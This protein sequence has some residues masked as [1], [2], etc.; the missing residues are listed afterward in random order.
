MNFT[1]DTEKLMKFFMSRIDKFSGV[2]TPLKQKK[3]DNILKMMYYDIK[4][5]D[6]WTNAEETQ[7][8]IRTHL[9]EGKENIAPSWVMEESKY[10]PTYIQNYI[11]EHNKGYIQY[12]L[13]IGDRDIEIYFSLLNNSDFNSL[14]QFDKYV[15]KMMT[16]LKIAFSYAPHKCSR[17]LKIYVFLTPFK[18][19]LPNNQ[20]HV[21]SQD[22]CNSA[23]TMSCN[24]HGEI[25]VYRK[26]EFFKVFIHETFHTLGLDFSTM[27][28][29]KFNEK[30]K[31]IFPIKSDF[32]LF[33]SYSEF[34]ASTMTIL[35]S[36]YFLLDDKADEENFYLYCD[37]CMRFEK[38]FALF[39]LVK[40]LDFMGLKYPN[41]Y[42]CD[43]ISL[44]ARRY[45]FKEKTNVFAYYIIKTL[46]L[47]NNVD[48]LLWCKKNNNNFI[49]FNKS[50][51]MLNIFLDFIKNIHNDTYFLNDIS[52]MGG[53]LSKMKGS[54][55]KPKHN[56]LTKTMRM[57]LCEIN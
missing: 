1:E 56:L 42:S 11:I 31:N 3:M 48:F 9:T 53:F 21:L 32:N 19:K 2:K 27:P 41:L 50:P 12:K 10:I 26:E 46:L 23:V 47:Y 25:I 24:P 14:G 38:M 7:N 18:K 43:K 15:K 52:R 6:M 17:V 54:H 4:S 49:C 29:N 34:W 20:F 55:S 51:R 8:K 35:I 13:T 45:L 44:T 57:S 36:S 40:I 30:V 28:L 39:Q 5:A 33:E 22:H 16:W 37:V